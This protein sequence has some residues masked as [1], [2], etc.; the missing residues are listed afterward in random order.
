LGSIEIRLSLRD[1]K[2]HVQ[3]TAYNATTRDALEASL[4]RLRELLADVGLNLAG[5]TV[6]EHRQAG[7]RSRRDRLDCEPTPGAHDSELAAAERVR[8]EPSAGQVDVYA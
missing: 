3:L 7:S 2:A 6:A 1:D 8:A 5:A 4:P